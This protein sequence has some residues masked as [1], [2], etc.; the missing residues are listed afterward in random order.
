MLTRNIF[1][2]A[3]TIDIFKSSLFLLSLGGDL[4]KN[5]ENVETEK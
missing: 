3:H 2:V 1:L 5:M 4:W